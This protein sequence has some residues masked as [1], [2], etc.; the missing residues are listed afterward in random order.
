MNSPIVKKLL[1]HG[2]ALVIM[3]VLAMLFFAPYVFDGKVL[4]QHD[5]VQASA[6][7]SE[8]E[9]YKAE[10]GTSPLWAGSYFSGM[11][12]YQIH[13]DTKGNLT[14]PVF[15]LLLAG[16]PMTSPFAELL[17]AM[18]CMYL[19]LSVMRV[20]WRLSLIGAIAFGIST[21]NMDIIAAGHSTKMVAL[22]YAPGILAGAILA[23]FE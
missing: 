20:D 1:P 6:S 9:K 17:L 12:A 7:Q 5:I 22:A 18:V 4:N 10:T 19:L 3:V 8:M 21:F 14:T 16:Q 2:I 15:R 11:P 23:K 13:L